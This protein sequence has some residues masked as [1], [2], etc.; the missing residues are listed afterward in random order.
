[1][2][3]RPTA[4]G[5]APAV[6]GSYELLHARGLKLTYRPFDLQSMMHMLRNGRCGQPWARHNEIGLDARLGEWLDEASGLW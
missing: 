2:A 1:M 3:Y 4:P 6:E 5:E